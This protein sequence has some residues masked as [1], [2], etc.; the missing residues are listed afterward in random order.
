MRSCGRVGVALDHHAAL[1]GR[2]WLLGGRL[3]LVK[4]CTRRTVY[5]AGC[6]AL[7]RL[8]QFVE[9]VRQ[10]RYSGL[11]H[12]V[13]L[14][15]LL[16]IVVLLGRLCLLVLRS[17]GLS[18]GLG[19]LGG[20]ELLVLGLVLGFVSV[21]QVAD[22]AHQVRC[23]GSMVHLVRWAWCLAAEAAS[24][25]AAGRAVVRSAIVHRVPA[26]PMRR[27]ALG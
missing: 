25:G 14:L 13:D 17:L 19:R 9:I 26:A 16:A 5:I 23:M 4:P 18:F 11:D 7:H 20:L 21:D 1:P 22:G 8:N 24:G 15:Q 27:T 2:C 3:G 10:R 6:L 12:F